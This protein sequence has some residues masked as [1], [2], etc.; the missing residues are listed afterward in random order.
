MYATLVVLMTWTGADYRP[1]VVQALAMPAAQCEAA[2][3]QA[4]HP[5]GWTVSAFCTP[6]GDP[7]LNSK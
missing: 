4:P 6:G 5:K 2:K 1:N 3:A 7:A